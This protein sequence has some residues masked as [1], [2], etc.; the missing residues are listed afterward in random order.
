GETP[1]LAA[2]AFPVRPEDGGGSVS[3]S[4]RG[5]TG[6]RL[7]PSGR[8]QRASGGN[9]SEKSCGRLDDPDG[10]QE[11]RGGRSSAGCHSTGR[12]HSPRQKAPILNVHTVVLEDP[13]G[14]TGALT[15]RSVCVV[16]A[17]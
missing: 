11:P 1:G 12:Q 9:G 2:G 17:L 16:Y 4:A 14:G 3:P 13:K 6:M 7:R 10:H 5:S 15:K 8:V